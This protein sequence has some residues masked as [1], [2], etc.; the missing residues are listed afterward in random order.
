MTGE[1]TSRQPEEVTIGEFRMFCESFKSSV[2]A[3]LYE[4]PTVNGTTGVTN[5]AVRSVKIRLA[6]R[7][8]ADDASA[9]AICML[10]N[11]TGSGG[12]E[13]ACHGLRFRD[14]IVTGYTAEDNGGDL[15]SLTVDIS[16]S[17]PAEIKEE[18]E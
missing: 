8:P 14:C 15:I 1:L 6:G 11:M 17:S 9:S 3:V 5:R 10:N 2:N 18:G 4:R 16:S 7:I 13:V 12:Y